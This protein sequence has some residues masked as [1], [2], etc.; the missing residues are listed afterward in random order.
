MNMRQS[1]NQKTDP[2]GW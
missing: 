2:V 1:P